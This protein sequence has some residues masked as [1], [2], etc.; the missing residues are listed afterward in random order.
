[1]FGRNTLVD[2]NQGEINRPP[3]YDLSDKGMVTAISVAAVLMS[4]TI[5]AM[6]LIADTIL[7][8]YTSLI[9]SS[10]F[11]GVIIFGLL[12]SGG[13]YLAM[14]GLKND[15]STLS[16]A[17][18]LMLIL[19]YGWL[20]GGILDPYNPELY[21]PAIGI[22][23]SI[24]V[25]ITLSVATI[26]YKTGRDFSNFLS[27]SSYAFLGVLVSSFIGFLIPPILLLSFCL[28]ISGFILLLFYEIW[29]ASSSQ[30]R[31]YENGMAIYVAFS[32]VFIHIL[33]IVLSFLAEQ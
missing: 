5:L 3:K 17:G 29:M 21:I 8:E 12:I 18:S 24:S 11:I 16:V 7:A 6:L 32:G 20:G 25:L 15:N 2:E 31:A 33:Q 19:S 30:R 28:A 26:V 4:L 13:R 1:M 22:A 14:K 9:Y 10:A 23:G 27:Y